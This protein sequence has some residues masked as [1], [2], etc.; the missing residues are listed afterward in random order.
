[1]FDTGKATLTATA[2]SNLDK[3]V[4]VFN[5]YADT[6]IFIYGHT[7]STGSDAIN[8]PLSEQRAASVRAYLVSKGLSSSR[9]QTSG[10]GSA[11]PISSNE[12]VEGR[13][14][15]RRVEFAIVAN[16]KM[17]KDAENEVKQ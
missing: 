17:L 8:Q 11:E 13:S 5:E 14:E 6:N 1:R 3:L 4:A 12:S 10:V 16:E 7:D 15:N 9:F 2:K